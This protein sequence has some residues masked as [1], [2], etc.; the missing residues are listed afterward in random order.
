MR[1]N[2]PPYRGRARGGPP[3][4]PP[5]LP[6]GLPPGRGPPREGPPRLSPRNGAPAGLPDAGRPPPSRPP[7]RPPRSPP[8]PPGSGRFGRAG[9][10]SSSRRARGARSGR[11]GRS[12]G[13]SRRGRRGFPGASGSD[14]RRSTSTRR[15]S[16]DEIAPTRSRVRAAAACRSAFGSSRRGW[17]RRGISSSSPA[18]AC[19]TVLGFGRARGAGLSRPSRSS[20]RAP[21]G[22]P[23]RSS[24]NRAVRGRGGRSAVLRFAGA[25]LSGFPKGA[26]GSRTG[27]SKSTPAS[28]ASVWPSWSLRTRVRT[29][30]TRPGSMSPS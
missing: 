30:S 28:W 21:R 6:P 18:S 11:A 4:R 22:R 7:G 12:A 20:K 23:P 3:G 14:T 8:N 9:R 24:S 1:Q 16:G 27:L 2:R 29:S 17:G 13:S 15:P 25:G 19:Q 5:G 10:A 26:M